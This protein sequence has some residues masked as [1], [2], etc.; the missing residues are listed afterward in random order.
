MTVDPADARFLRQ[1]T[2]EGFGAPAQERLAAAH[3]VVV[4]AG[5]LGATVLPTLAAAGVGRITIVDDDTVDTTNLH[6]QTIYRPEDAGRPKA[7]AA[8]AALAALAPG[9]EAVPVV[10]RFAA[11][12]A[13]DLVL[14]ADVIVEG[15]DDA[16]TRFLANDIAAVRGIPLVW[17]SA[18]GWHG[19]AGV[20]WDERG[21]DYRD[22][23]AEPSG[24]QADCAT[25]GVLPAVC[26]VIGGVMAGEA[27]KLVTGVGETLLGRVVLFDARTGRVRELAYRRDP[28]A[29]RPGS[30]EERT[31]EVEPTESMSLD[32]LALAAELDGESP[33]LLIDVREPHEHSYVAIPGSTL[34]PLR[35]LAGSVEG[36]DRDADIVLYCHHGARSGQ[37]LEAMRTLG[38]T[39]VRHLAGGIDAYS[40]VVDPGLPRY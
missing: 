3:V 6:R 12:A 14:D 37:A 21:V 29:V 40:R 28:G 18:L 13:L 4:G 17:G 39:S 20:A 5:G 15:S 9:V 7:E 11:G 27:I 2:L 31:K 1:R 23:A 38:F 33:P 35:E 26:T 34:I 24:P 16:P 22:L 32:P 25:V 36:L 30:I 19:Q 8:A 10:G